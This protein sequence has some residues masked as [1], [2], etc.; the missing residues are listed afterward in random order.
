MH[1]IRWRKS[2]YSW[3]LYD[4]LH[5]KHLYIGIND[6]PAQ[7]SQEWKFKMNIK[8]LLLTNTFYWVD[9]FIYCFF[10]VSVDV[11]QNVN[12]L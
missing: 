10:V 8:S 2:V 11:L 6:V 5:G 1:L 3:S 12:Y 7:F 9:E 4:T